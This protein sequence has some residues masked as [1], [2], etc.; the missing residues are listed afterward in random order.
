[1]N[2][3]KSPSQRLGIIYAFI[4]LFLWGI[5]GPAGRFLAL[6]GVNMYF[7]ASLRFFIG[8]F[9]FFVFLLFKKA[10]SFDF[11]KNIRLTLIIALIGICGNSV[12]YHITLKYLPGSLVMVLENLSPIFVLF[13]SFILEKT[14][15]RF[16]EI[17]SLFLSLAGLIFIVLGKGHYSFSGTTFYLGIFLGVLTGLT[18]GF[19]VYFSAALVKPLKN[20]TV[21]IVQY[22]FRIFLISSVLMSPL[23]FTKG[24]LPSTF[25]QWFWLLE[26]GVFQSGFAYIFWNY[27]L[28][29]LPTNKT[30]IL[31]LMTIIFTTINE[32]LFMHLKLNSF[33]IT[34]GI[35]V[36]AGGFCFGSFIT[37]W[38]SVLFYFYF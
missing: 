32:I 10:V 35:L 8:T 37:D 23:L 29:I 24:N 11:S 33:V 36:M 2:E 22:L 31:F 4:A 34:G 28:S 13:F 14:R 18:F 9:V 21:S 26:M 5:H 3:I 15:P 38:S 19:Y 17:A 7:V 6:E 27:A 12:L 20:D 30:S 25:P 1:M 16:I